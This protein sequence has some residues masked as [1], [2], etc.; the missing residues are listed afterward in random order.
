MWGFQ[1]K[2]SSALFR[3]W[4]GCHQ[5]P[6]WR[7][8]HHLNPAATFLFML[9]GWWVSLQSTV[10]S[11]R[12][13]NFIYPSWSPNLTSH[14]DNNG[15]V[16][17]FSKQALL[18]IRS[19]RLLQVTRTRSEAVLELLVWSSHWPDLTRPRSHVAINIASAEAGLCT[20][21][22]NLKL[23]GI[24]H[25]SP[26]EYLLIFVVVLHVPS[27]LG[28]SRSHKSEVLWGPPLHLMA[29]WL[30]SIYIWTGPDRGI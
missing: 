25:R 17:R 18:Q 16:V 8:L 1:Q 14:Q 27:W 21:I 20:S 10:L 6:G 12:S 26:L 19:R 22:L 13:T 23:L 3:A 7:Q 30:V 24:L 15:S 2:F 29:G 5:S 4:S 11:L 28:P 9:E